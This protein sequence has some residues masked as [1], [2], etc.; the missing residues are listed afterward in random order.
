NP[1]STGIGVRP[2]G[3]RI[4][5][6]ADFT[7]SPSLMI[8][9]ATLIT[10][11]VRSVMRW[12]AFELVQLERRGLPVVRD[13]RPIPHTSRQGWLA[14]KDC[15]PRNPFR[16]DIDEPSWGV[17]SGET[18]SLRQ[19]AGRTVRYFWRPIRQLSD[20]FTFRLI[21]SVIH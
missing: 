17:T 12:P 11:I 5:V 10:G 9:T 1:R 15:Y 21:G 8:A 18:L 16:A 6:T 20:P 3:D 19:I 7:P 13:F 14:R 4:E 2:R